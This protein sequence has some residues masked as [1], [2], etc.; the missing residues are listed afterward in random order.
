MVSPAE[1]N[2]EGWTS[3][4]RVTDLLSNMLGCLPEGR[5]DEAS[6]E[7]TAVLE[8]FSQ[9]DKSE[10][11]LS[12]LMRTRPE[13]GNEYLRPPWTGAAEAVPEPLDPPA[14]G[15][16][17]EDYRGVKIILATSAW[18]SNPGDGGVYVGNG[19]AFCPRSNFWGDAKEKIS[20]VTGRLALVRRPLYVGAE[21]EVW[22]AKEL[23]DKWCLHAQSDAALPTTQVEGLRELRTLVGEGLSVCGLGLVLKYVLLGRPSQL[24]NYARV[25]PTAA[26]KTLQ[27]ELTPL[28][29]MKMPEASSMEVKVVRTLQRLKEGLEVQQGDREEVQRELSE[30]GKSAWEWMCVL[31]LNWAHRGVKKEETFAPFHASDHSSAQKAVMQ[32]IVRCVAHFCAGD[33]RV[34]PRQWEEMSM[35]RGPG[36]CGGVLHQAYAI[37]WEAVKE[38]FWTLTPSGDAKRQKFSRLLKSPKEWTQTRVEMV[39]RTGSREQNQ[40]EGPLVMVKSDEEWAT[41]VSELAARDIVEVA[42]EAGPGEQRMPAFCGIY[43]IHRSWCATPHGDPKRLLSLVFDVDLVN[44]LHKDLAESSDVV[45]QNH[46][47]AGRLVAHPQGLKVALPELY[48]GAVEVYV[49]EEIWRG[50]FVLNKEVPAEVFG[51]TGMPRRPRLRLV[52]RGWHN[53]MIV[54]HGLRGIA[55][56]LKVAEGW[57]LSIP[58]LDASAGWLQHHRTVDG[59]L[60]LWLGTTESC[61]KIVLMEGE[62]SDDHRSLK[63]WFLR[64]TGAELR[65]EA[66]L[67]VELIGAALFLLMREGSTQATMKGIRS[68]TNVM[69]HISRCSLA[70]ASLLQPMLQSVLDR[71]SSHLS[72]EGGDGLWVGLLCTLL[73]GLPL[74]LKIGPAVAP[75]RGATS[76]GAAEAAQAGPCFGA[77][78][79]TNLGA[80]YAKEKR[81][82]AIMVIEEFGGVG[83]LTEAL[84]L[85][86]ICPAGIV[87]VEADEKLRRHFKQ[88]HPDA[89]VFPSIEKVSELDI[90][91]WRKCFPN[92]T[93]V[94]HG[95]GWPC[96]DQSR[97]NANRL[98]ADSAR[99]KLLEPMLQISS[100]LKNASACRG[101]LPWRV[102]EFYENV[103][104]DEADKKIVFEK[105][106]CAPHHIKGDQFMVCRRPRQFWLRNLEI[107]LGSDLT[108]QEVHCGKPYEHFL[109]VECKTELL[110]VQSYLQKGAERLKPDAGPWPTFTRPVKKVTPP[111]IA[112]GL[113]TA[114]EAAKNRWKGDAYRLQVYHYEDDWLI[115]D[116]AGVR[117]LK[118][119]ECS[120]MMGLNSWHFKNTKVRF[121]EDEMG[122]AVGN[123]FSVVVAA[124]L[125]C[126]LLPAAQSYQGD[127]TKAIWKAWLEMEELDD[128]TVEEYRSGLPWLPPKLLACSLHCQLCGSA[129]LGGGQVQSWMMAA[130]SVGLGVKLALW[131]ATQSPSMLS[132]TPGNS[133][134]GIFD[135]NFDASTFQWKS[136]V[137]Y[138]VP[139]GTSWNTLVNAA[140][141]AIKRILRSLT[142]QRSVVLVT[143]KEMQ[144]AHVLCSTAGAPAFA[145]QR[146]ASLLLAARVE[147]HVLWSSHPLSLVDGPP[148]WRNAP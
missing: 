1:A 13:L 132:L 42:D 135:G 34:E 50:D 111:T 85:L 60:Q 100:W 130:P 59:D 75:D 79:K 40:Y 110:S 39:H 123:M 82:E 7:W 89:I 54:V 125:L 12:R 138:K 144:D 121:T 91:T 104:F 97:L 124:R 71:E 23:V 133:G 140:E 53:G 27:A 20:P 35:K 107:P 87:F 143:V 58:D 126:G 22:N 38:T 10:V 78:R 131:Q 51:M 41:V 94:L 36:H 29:P 14:G 80:H 120:K 77:G 32:R 25:L 37:S 88:R 44:V 72:L 28:L 112:A 76:G 67:L 129:V 4:E 66:R 65:F 90:L 49:L 113:K 139:A 141:A 92:V 17:L 74:K 63:P 64:V 86:G 21:D 2:F 61:E 136:L 8:G 103:M 137:H 26:L 98:G 127:L 46:A 84:K 48:G 99:G 52:P 30:V 114:S 9:R 19:S 31:A 16:V 93:L 69:V 106:G 148:R 118:A 122:Q 109:A 108:I 47:R 15:R 81:H 55:P 95:G 3:D 117:R 11:L 119:I 62:Q 115:R 146:L 56:V 145:V 128:E 101:C 70:G 105:I 6:R 57:P 68:L 33:K 43:G 83:S 142:H 116:Q 96:Q 18:W 134:L 147:L 5:R 45:C 102:V 73:H 24:G